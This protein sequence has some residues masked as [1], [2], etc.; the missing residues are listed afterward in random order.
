MSESMVHRLTVDDFVFYLPKGRFVYLPTG[1]FW[2]TVSVNWSVGRVEIPRRAG[3]YGPAYVKASD[4]IME[5]RAVTQP[6]AG[7]NTYKKIGRR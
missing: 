6:P 1:D 4:W 5:H 7:M 2:P 3:E